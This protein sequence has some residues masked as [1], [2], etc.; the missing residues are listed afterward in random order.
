MKN[1]IVLL[2][3]NIIHMDKKYGKH[4][5]CV[6]LYYC[7]LPKNVTLLSKQWHSYSKY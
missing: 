2:F 4:G 1:G 6:Y 7:N 5:K 3:K